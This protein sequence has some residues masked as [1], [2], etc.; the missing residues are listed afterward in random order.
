MDTDLKTRM[1]PSLALLTIAKMFYKEH[2]VILENENIEE[3][4]YDE[5]VD[6]V[7]ITVTVDVMPRAI[8]IAGKFKSRGIPV[9]AGG[10]HI[11]ANPRDAEAYFDAICIGMAE[12]TWPQII[13][14]VQNHALKKVYRCKEGIRGDEIVSPAYELIVNS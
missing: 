8:E 4:H 7:G 5:P 9:V 11:T 2:Q 1:A 3:I 6:V 10:I 14:D 13:Q 12:S